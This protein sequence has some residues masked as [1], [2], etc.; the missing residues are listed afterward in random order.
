MSDIA[1]H[2][3][4]SLASAGGH[5]DT[6]EYLVEIHHCDPRRKLI[7]MQFS[8]EKFFEHT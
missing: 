7:V 2:T 8:N 4:L 1:G 3:P 6:V 5:L